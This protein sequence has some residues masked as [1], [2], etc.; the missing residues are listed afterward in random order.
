[1]SVK[2]INEFTAREGMENELYDF[3]KNLIPFIKESEGNIDC[4]V[5]RSKED[6]TR[7]VVLEEWENESFHKKSVENYPPDKMREAMMLIGAPPS[8]EYFE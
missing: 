8:G 4:V 6:R 2:R 3:L 5:L 1:M 7:I